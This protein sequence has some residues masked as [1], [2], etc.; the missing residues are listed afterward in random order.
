M[1]GLHRQGVVDLLLLPVY[2][3]PRQERRALLM[4][5]LALRPAFLNHQSDSLFGHSLQQAPGSSSAC[6]A[7][8][9]IDRSPN[10]PPGRR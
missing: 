9:T 4:P 5:R 6:S 7:H 1:L 8:S 3:G 2:G 10:L